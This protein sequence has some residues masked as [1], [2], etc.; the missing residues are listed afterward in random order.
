MSEKRQ[1]H[2]NRSVDGSSGAHASTSFS[3][4]KLKTDSGYNSKDVIDLSFHDYR[5]NDPFKR[6]P[7][8]NLLE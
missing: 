7:V 8:S 5:K 6:V 4:K 2:E 3:N 1:F